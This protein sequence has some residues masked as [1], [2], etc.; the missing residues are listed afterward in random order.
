MSASGLG[1]GVWIAPPHGLGCSRSSW[2]D[3]A[4]SH[5]AAAAAAA[6]ATNER[7]LKTA[8]LR[9]TD[10]WLSVRCCGMMEEGK[11]RRRETV[12]TRKPREGDPRLTL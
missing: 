11:K 4:G 8:M 7:R 3:T 10:C 6:A 12:I 5:D 2:A 9:L 1:A